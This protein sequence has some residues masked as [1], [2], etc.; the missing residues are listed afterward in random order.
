MP[1][2]ELI[3][4]NFIRT[5]SGSGVYYIDNESSIYIVDSVLPGSTSGNRSLKVNWNENVSIRW[6]AGNPPINFGGNI[7]I[8]IAVRYIN[9]NFLQAGKKAEAGIFIGDISAG[10]GV[11]R[12]SSTYQFYVFLK[13]NIITLVNVQISPNFFEQI[14]LRQ[15]T[16]QLLFYYS[17]SNPNNKNLVGTFSVSTTPSS[18]QAGFFLLTD[19]KTSGIVLFDYFF[20]EEFVG[21]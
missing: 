3:H 7:R 11:I 16:N 19:D 21:A 8:G 10:I 13:K 9:P 14:F 1:V 17:F 15:T 6:I 4:T 20:V 12:V 2:I 5:F 18:G